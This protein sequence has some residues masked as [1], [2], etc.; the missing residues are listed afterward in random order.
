MENQVPDLEP[1]RPYL[2]ILARILLDPRLRA[3]LGASDVVQQTLMDAHKNIEQ[4]HGN[5]EAEMAAWLRQILVHDLADAVRA[6]GRAK[7]DASLEVAI[8]DS[9]CRLDAWVAASQSSPSRRAGREE[10]A[11]RLAEAM[12]RLPE[13]QRTAVELHKLL[14]YSL[15]ETA[16]RMGKTRGSVA[17]L[18]VRGVK[19]LRKILGGNGQ[20]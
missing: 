5:T 4:F 6:L 3:K 15:K 11:V 2:R 12:A 10:E 8:H 18:I 20:T 13:D 14:E 1:F 9:S 19:G 7:R 17:S 16:E